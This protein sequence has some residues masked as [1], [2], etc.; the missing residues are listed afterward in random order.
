MNGMIYVENQLAPNT[1]KRQVPARPVKNG[2]FLIGDKI[3]K[4]QYIGLNK[5]EWECKDLWGLTI[6]RCVVLWVDR[7]Q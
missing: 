6:S 3:K 7:V 5:I 2:L 1:Q 4:G